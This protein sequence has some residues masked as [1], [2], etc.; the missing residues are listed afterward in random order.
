MTSAID[1]TKPVYGSPTTDSVRTNFT[2]AASEIT[3]LQTKTNSAPF[4]PTSGGTM[5]GPV[6]LAADP[7]ANLQAATKQYVDTLAF[8]GAGTSIPDAPKD[9][10]FYGRGGAPTPAGPNDW[11]S[12][13][14]VT[15]VRVGITATTP[16]FSLRTDAT[17][18]YYGLD[19]A[20]NSLRY[21]R[22]SSTLDFM[23]S[24]SSVA[25]LAA[26]SAIFPKLAVTAAPVAGTDVVNKT[27][28]D[29]K[30]ID[31]PNDTNGYLRKGGAWA[32]GVA[33]LDAS[34]TVTVTINNAAG[35]KAPVLSA[36]QTAVNAASDAFGI[37]G[38]RLSDGNNDGAGIWIYGATSS[39]GAIN[40]VQI[41]A[42]ATAS[43][44]A[45]NFNADGSSYFPGTLSLNPS[46]GGVNLILN[47]A[48]TAGTNNI[49]GYKASSL[50]WLN[51]I[52]DGTAEGAGTVGSNYVIARYNN[53]GTYIDS[54]ISIDRGIGRTTIGGGPSDPLMLNSSTGNVCRILYN[55]SGVRQWSGGVGTSGNFV[56]ADETNVRSHIMF[57]GSSPTTTIYDNVNIAGG[58]GIMTGTHWHKF[59]WDG[60]SV[61]Y[62][63]DG[64]AASGTLCTQTNAKLFSYTGGTGGPTGVSLNGYDLNT[65]L[66]GIYVDAVSDERIKENIQPTDI[67]ALAALLNI[68]V[69]QFDIKA[70]VAHYLSSL[71]LSEEQKAAKEPESAHIPI[72][73]VAQQVKSIISEAVNVL[74]HPEPPE[75]SPMP[76][77]MH[78][79][80]DA[81]FTPYLIRAI[82]QLAARVKDLEVNGND[83]RA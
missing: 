38:K 39:T 72:G 82:Q 2:T 7:S 11:S 49:G 66:Y 68:E 9:G 21:N 54:P 75:E 3:A 10:W 56:I 44:K 13:P 46:S 32:F 57:D 55:L 81:N 59:D 30:L 73:L 16:L 47:A 31:A 6:V 41:V 34:N 22:A 70:D 61:T 63:I 78:T 33:Q 74:V 20:T 65:Q 52:G 27:Y 51:V 18:N 67:D 8:G 36:Y 40:T 48:T 17:Y 62:I 53:S 71:G 80:I 15:G 28:A 64:G 50:R 79:L 35:R 77:D 12:N 14:V 26:G 83:A 19:I 42:G 29:L 60:K 76:A 23:F 69:N 5:T 4:L 37:F 43:S 58:N 1:I 45:W 24:G 25:T